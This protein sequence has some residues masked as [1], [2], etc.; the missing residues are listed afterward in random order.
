[1]RPRADWRPG[2]RGS[3]PMPA[4]LKPRGGREAQGTPRRDMCRRARRNLRG[5]SQNVEPSP[6]EYRPEPQLPSLRSASCVRGWSRT[7]RARPWFA[8]AKCLTTLLFEE[9]RLYSVVVRFFKRLHHKTDRACAC[10]V[11]IAQADGQRPE[12]AASGQGLNQEPSLDCS[13]SRM[14]TNFV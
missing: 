9:Y 10:P 7:C 1:M 14:S 12:G 11:L 5:R 6:A 8:A 13:C 2:S 4:R 3:V